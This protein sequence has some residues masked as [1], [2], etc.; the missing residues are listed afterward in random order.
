MLPKIFFTQPNIPPPFLGAAVSGAEAGPARS[1][2]VAGGRGSC[3]RSSRYPRSGRNTGR[4]PR[5]SSRRSSRRGR[6]LP[7]GA[8]SIRPGWAPLW[9]GTRRNESLSQLCSTRLGVSGG[10]IFSSGLGSVSTG[11]AETS[12]GAAGVLAATGTSAATGAATGASAATG[13]ATSGAGATGSGAGGAASTTGA[14]GA[15][16][17]GGA[18]G[19]LYSLG[20]A[21]I[22]TAVGL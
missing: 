12:A 18:K 19:F 15:A 6:G 11:A 4:S 7:C 9:T 14:A 16:G 17:A 10:R 22:E 1:P 21:R 5:R 20:A 8:S 3:S 13:V 2:A